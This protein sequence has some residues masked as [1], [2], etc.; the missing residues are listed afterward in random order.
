M[1]NWSKSRPLDALLE[2]GDNVYPS[3]QVYLF[4]NTIGRPYANLTARAP[5][6]AAMGNHD[7]KTNMGWDQIGYL[8]LPGRTFEKI[9]TK[10][11]ISVQVLVLDSDY[12]DL[13]GQT[14]W[15]A[16]KVMEGSFTWRI[17][18]FHH[19]VWSCGGHGS[20]PQVVEK[21][22]PILQN[23][24]HL[25]LSGHDHL[26]QRFLVDKTTYIVTGGGGA[27]TYPIQTCPSGTPRAAAGFQRHHFV[28]IEVSKDKIGLD[29]VARTGESLEKV[30]ILKS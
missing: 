2:A 19:P 23:R 7:V 25:V 18:M 22:Q 9:V 5:L 26:Y 3:G 24:V 20:T 17:V 10:G 12:I 13:Y 29:V 21:W 28:G 15:L 8:G 1:E 16:T 14:A 30:S 6:W 27:P 4:E 11:D